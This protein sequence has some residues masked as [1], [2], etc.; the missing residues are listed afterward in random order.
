SSLRALGMGGAARGAAAGSDA[1]FAN[2][3]G[4]SVL[5]EYVMEAGYA[6]TPDAAAHVAHLVLADNRT[7]WLGAAPAY[8]YVRAAPD[9]GVSTRRHELALA[10]SATVAGKL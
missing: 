1:P 8:T 7:S 6:Y 4:L 10:L 9:S 2:P 5:R 3:S